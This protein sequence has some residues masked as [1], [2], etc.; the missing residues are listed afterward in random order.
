M[1]ENGGSVEVAGVS[2]GAERVTV[3]VP[4]PPRNQINV[5]QR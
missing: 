4:E 2:S 3:T 1:E 5:G